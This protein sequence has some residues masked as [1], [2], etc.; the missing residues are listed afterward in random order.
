MAGGLEI[1]LHIEGLSLDVDEELTRL[2]KQIASLGKDRE[3]SEKKLASK[4]FTGKAPE[5]VVRKERDKL[6]ETLGAL[7]R[8]QARHDLLKSLS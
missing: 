1:C 4:G 3:R 8:L 2:E 6:A 7:S 5:A